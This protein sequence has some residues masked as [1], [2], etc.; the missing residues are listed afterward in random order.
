MTGTVRLG[1]LCAGLVVFAVG[2]G[3]GPR[4]HAAEGL[5]PGAL[6]G[7]LL[8]AGGLVA[9]L[10]AAGR[11][12]GATRRRWWAPVVALLLVATALALWTLGQAV[13]A[14][15]PPRPA[16][17]GRTPADVG[18][19]YSDVT[20]PSSD[21]TALAG[22]YVPSRNGAAVVLMH[23]AGSTRSAVLDH[24]RVLADHGYGVLLFDAR[25]HGQSAGRGMDFGWFGES[26][27]SGAVDF[28]AARPDVESARIGLVGMSMG[29]EQAIGAAGADERVRAV[30]AEGATHRVAADKGYLDAYG[31]RGELQQRVDRVTYGLAGLLTSAPEPV[32]LR[33]SV[34]VATR[35]PDP[36]AFLLVTAGDVPNESLAADHVREGSTTGVTTWNVAGAGH[37]QGLATAPDAWEEHVVAFLDDALGR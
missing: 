20:F 9:A 28:L 27:A 21:G 17:D 18:L 24:A 16:L 31:V 32:P 7:Y 11:I 13:A 30:V 25:G 3:L 36:A 5:G 34:S 10:W 22:W 37:T 8:L 14:S 19:V 29:G 35:R 26:D 23:G 1:V 2:V 33:R 15:F 12:L 6:T 4:H